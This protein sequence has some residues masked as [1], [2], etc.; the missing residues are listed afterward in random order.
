MLPKEL[1][2]K[3][4]SL[5]FCGYVIKP[6]DIKTCL[7]KLSDLSGMLNSF[8]IRVIKA[9]RPRQKLIIDIEL[10]DGFDPLRLNADYYFYEFVWRLKSVSRNF[11]M[12]IRNVPIG[13]FPELYFHAFNRIDFTK[14][15]YRVKEKYFLYNY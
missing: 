9:E 15:I 5:A 6:G 2:Q 7:L 14:S 3:G 13:S 12:Y 11:A 10:A 4:R 1:I 8:S